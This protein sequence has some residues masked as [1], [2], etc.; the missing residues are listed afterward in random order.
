MKGLISK[1]PG[2][3]TVLKAL[4]YVLTSLSS[5]AGSEDY[6]KNR[7][8]RGGNSGTGSY[9]KLALFKANMLNAFVQEHA[10]DT[11][12]EYGCGDGNQLTLA[13][14]P[15]YV[16]FDVSIDAVTRCRQLFAQDAH[17]TFK[18]VS[19]Y[20]DDKAALTL[21]LDVVYHLVEDT[22]F[23]GYMQRLFDSS[24]QYVVIYSSDTDVQ[25]R[26]QS[27]H[28]RHRQFSAWIAQHRPAWKLI[29][30][31]PNQ[32]P[33]QES[34]QTGSPADFFVYQRVVGGLDQ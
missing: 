30:H 21:S 27:P 3:H 17:K 16:G 8:R 29:R 24:T 5:F 14:Y 6:W 28:V 11:V 25:E 12:I 31:I 33:L 10:I 18:L 4:N 26:F 1:V 34:D 7:Y 20:R 23:D 22:V 32:Y 15:Q 9:D 2:L 13:K 19:D